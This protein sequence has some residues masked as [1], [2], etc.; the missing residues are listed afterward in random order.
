[1]RDKLIGKDSDDYD[2]TL[3]NC[4]G[5][6]FSEAFISFL[7]SI[8]ITEHSLIKNPSQSQHLGT[9]KVCISGKIWV[10]FNSL[11]CERY[12]DDSRIPE[13]SDGTPFQDSQRRDFIFHLHE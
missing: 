7:E 11:R 6:E 13:V 9:C 4:S 1:M 12:N 3:E 8:G 10:D 5:S 2:I